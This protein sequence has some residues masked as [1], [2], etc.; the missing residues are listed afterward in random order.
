M[1]LPKIRFSHE[2]HKMPVAVRTGG[3][4]TKLAQVFV[5][6]R[7][8][9]TELIVEYDTRFTWD[10]INSGKIVL[11]HYVL[12]KGK[13]LFL[14]LLSYYQIK[15]KSPEHQHIGELWSTIRRHMPEKEAYY[16]SLVGKEVEIVIEANENDKK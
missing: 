5:T 4:V 2:Y 16:R 7:E 1:N 8:E 3:M 15:S 14:L 10:D 12:P 6:T 11:D 9:L 13:V